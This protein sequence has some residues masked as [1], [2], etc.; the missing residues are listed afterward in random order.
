MVSATVYVPDLDLH[1][2]APGSNGTA[3]ICMACLGPSP[4]FPST[5]KAEHTKANAHGK[6]GQRLGDVKTVGPQATQTRAEQEGV[7]KSG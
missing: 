2:K 5:N 6:A 3:D 1:P 7:P 4:T